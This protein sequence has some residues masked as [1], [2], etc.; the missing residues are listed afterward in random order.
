MFQTAKIES[1]II[2]DT[3]LQNITSGNF[4]EQQYG[5]VNMDSLMKSST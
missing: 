4:L 2:S 1:Q 3:R 5:V